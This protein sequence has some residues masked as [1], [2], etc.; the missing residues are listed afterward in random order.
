MFAVVVGS[1]VVVSSYL[2]L[3]LIILLFIVL[4]VKKPS[5]TVVNNCSTHSVSRTLTYHPAPVSHPCLTT[6][7][8]GGTFVPT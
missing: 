4:L 1:C 2:F 7:H 5:L 6:H 3:S 8:K